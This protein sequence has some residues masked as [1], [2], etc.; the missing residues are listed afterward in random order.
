MKSMVFSKRLVLIYTLIVIIPL[1]VV[2]ITFSEYFKK[3]SY[4]ELI[5]ASEKAVSEQAAEINSFIESFALIESV[6]SGNNDL[7]YFFSSPDVIDESEMIKTVVN[8]AKEIE[9][10]LFVLPKI[11]GIRIFKENE[12]ILERW[13]VILNESRADAGSLKKWEFNYS[14]DFLGNLDFLKDPSVCK[15]IELQLNKRHIG[16]LQ[17]SMK[18]QDFFPFLYD[19]KN[20]FEDWYLINNDEYLEVSHT[21]YT[22]AR[23]SEENKR[24]LLNEIIHSDSDTGRMIMKINRTDTIFN[25]Q[26]IN[27]MDIAVIHSTSTNPIDRTLN[28]L[29]A[30]AIGISLISVFLIFFIIRFTTTKLLRRIYSLIDGM[31]RVREG[32]FNTSVHVDGK[33][34]IAESQQVFNV[35]VEK[36]RDQIEEIKKEQA[37][38][39]ETEIKAMQSQIN[40]HFLYN[41]LETIKMQAELNDQDDITQSI[42]VLGKMMRYC[43]HWRNHRVTIREEIEYAASYI[44]LINLRNDYV[45]HMDTSIEKQYED[46][47]IPKMVL[48]PVIENAFFYAVEPKGCDAVISIFTKFDDEKKQLYLCVRD[49]GQ[50]VSEEKLNELKKSVNSQ[51]LENTKG[52]IGLKN[53]Q[54]RL[55]MFYGKDYSIEIMS[56]E[57]EGMEVR[58]PVKGKRNGN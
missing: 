48:Q 42:T 14:A 27:T 45:V 21:P 10:L 17:V 7:K 29:T 31:R 49:Y 46:F 23:L 35:M 12:N 36:I 38:V 56:Y 54:Q 15:T 34:E 1:S 47:E 8:E 13:P 28:M 33:D 44:F 52:H 39:S 32:D 16:Y 26:K 41:V 18:M 30:G 4:A 53:I 40:T 37:L 43:L 57:G 22:D 20:I 51:E 50:G 55:Y 9:R 2:L 5:A 3:N 24:I 6:I 19:N 11:Y 25:W 58:I